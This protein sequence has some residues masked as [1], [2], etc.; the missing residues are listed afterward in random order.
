MIVGVCKNC[1]TEITQNYCP[2]CGISKSL[3]RIDGKY[4]AN[5]IGSV[6]NFDKGI[7]YTIKELIIRPGNT[8]KE[9]ILN[10][11]N[12]IV[13]PIIF[14]IICSLIYSVLEKFLNFENGYIYYDESI[15][16]TS[17]SIFGW[18][19]ENYG[20]GNLIMG[21][22][23]AFWTKVLFKKYSYNYYEI[24]ILLCFVMGIGM[25]ILAVFGT[26]EWITKLKI[27][28]FGGMLFL[29]YYTW[30]IGQFFDKKKF[31]SYLKAFVSY[32]LGM[33]TFTIG[34]FVIGKIIDLII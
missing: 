23:I 32:F 18:V 25:L 15:K 9:F 28:Q 34:V 10:D 26:I 27:L 21:I 3:K 12:R 17:M 30:A 5:E 31:S 11:R 6:L 4:I 24:L 8:V 2:N 7:L 20:Y 19:K 16:S 29:V 14:I 33:I 13:K 1:K 22:F